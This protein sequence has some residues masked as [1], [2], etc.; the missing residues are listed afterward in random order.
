[1]RLSVVEA[2]LVA[3]FLLRVAASQAVQQ[4]QQQQLWQRHHLLGLP[5]GLPVNG[6]GAVA[7]VLEAKIN[8]RKPKRANK[9]SRPCSRWARAK[10][11]RD[12]QRGK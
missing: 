10:R 6:D 9:G 11:F 2:P 7:D 1:M 12:S 4:Q 8:T 3:E 5:S